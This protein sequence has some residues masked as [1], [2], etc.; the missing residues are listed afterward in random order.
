MAVIKA[1]Q[2]L[3]EL[4]KPLLARVADARQPGDAGSGRP[5][6]HTA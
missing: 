1:L 4:K 2:F 6:Y 3:E 5:V